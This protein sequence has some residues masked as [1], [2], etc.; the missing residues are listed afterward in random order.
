ML[1]YCVHS[2]KDRAT[3]RQA[4]NKSAPHDLPYSRSDMRAPSFPVRCRHHFRMPF[5]FLVAPMRPASSNPSWD[6][7]RRSYRASESASDVQDECSRATVSHMDMIHDA[8]LAT[9]P[10]FEM[11]EEMERR[12]LG[13]LE[14]GFCERWDWNRDAVAKLSAEDAIAL[15]RRIKA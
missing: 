10:P 5:A 9:A 7:V 6:A 4:D 8:L 2:G 1:S 13:W 11:I 12:G 3:N 15:Y 14:G